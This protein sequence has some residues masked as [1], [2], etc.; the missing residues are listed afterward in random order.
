MINIIDVTLRD[1]GYQTNFNF[2]EE[3]LQTIIYSIN[4]AKIEYIEVGYRKGSIRPIRDIGES[5]ICSR[6]YI[7]KCAK[8]SNYSKIAVMLHAKNITDA[9]LHELYNIGVS[10]CRICLTADDMDNS[11]ACIEK[12]KS[13][14]LKV[15]VNITRVTQYS[16]YCLNDIFSKLEKLEVDIIYIAD[17]NGSI[18]PTYV[19]E[20]TENYRKIYNIPFGFHAHENL[21]LAQANA[22]VAI[23]SGVQY[24]DASINGLGKGVGNLRLELFVA[25]LLAQGYKKYNIIPLVKAANELNKS[26]DNGCLGI[27][28]LAMGIYDLSIDDVCMKFGEE[29]KQYAAI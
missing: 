11:L 6:S 1:G 24:I 23:D 15:C 21:G 13:Y 7:E 9:D 5:G 16:R 22:I 28:Q 12:A 18:F 3:L 8:L 14:G 26:I 4:E 10:L 2:S 29:G 20:V 25:Y 17:S 27:N 19:K